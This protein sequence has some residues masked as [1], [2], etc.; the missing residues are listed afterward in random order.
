VSSESGK[1]EVYVEP[2]PATGERWQVSTA[3]G[4]EPHWRRDGGELFYLTQDQWI[5]V[6]PVPPDGMWGRTAPNRLFKVS[7]PE[8]VGGSDYSV[9][10]SGEI[11]VNTV[12]ANQPVT[13]PVQVVVNWTSLLKPH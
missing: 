1:A 4:A 13:P 11:V 2:V 12:Q 6:M 5:A 10:P 7:V 8:L 3:G 9:S